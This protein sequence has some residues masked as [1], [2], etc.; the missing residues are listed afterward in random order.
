MKAYGIKVVRFAAGWYDYQSW[1]DYYWLNKPAFYA[2]MDK[3]IAAAEAAGI[4]LICSL[5][6]SIKGFAELTHYTQGT[7]NGVKGLSMPSQPEYQLMATYIAEFVGRYKNSPAIYA[8]A[9]GNEFSAQS[10]NEFHRSW[11]M[12]GTDAVAGSNANLGTRPDGS[13]YAATDKLLTSDYMRY[14]RLVNAL[15]RANDPHGRIVISGNAIGTSFAVTARTFNALT[16][17][18]KSMWDGTAATEFEPWIAYRDREYPVVCQHVYPGAGDSVGTFFGDQKLTYAQH[19][20]YAKTCADAV[21]KPL[22]LEEWG[23]TRYGSSVDPGTTTALQEQT[24]FNNGLAA[25]QAANIGVACLWNWDGE[26]AGA[27]EW[28]RW[29]LTDST[30]V[31]QLQAIAAVNAAR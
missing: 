1:R 27:A 12:D 21:N 29:K 13:T 30:R 24:N 18:T 16:A 31:Y 4:G 26:L 17:D 22:I 6:W 19:I 9:F 11:K 10:G 7:T 15:I 3:V 2:A 14:A 5:T 23:S 25:I 20:T 28:Q 8:W